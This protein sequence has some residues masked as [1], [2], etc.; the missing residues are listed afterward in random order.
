[1][2]QPKFDLSSVP[3]KIWVLLTVI[4]VVVSMMTGA[5]GTFLYRFTVDRPG[6]CDSVRVAQKVL[7]SVVTVSVTSTRGTSS[8]SGVIVRADGQILTNDHV[9]S[10]AGHN[11]TITIL[12]NSGLQLPATV[13]GTDPLT[14]LALLK[15]NKNKLPALPISWREPL[16]VGQP[17]V[18]LGAPLG[19]S[20]SVT[21]GIVSALDRNVPAPMSSGGTTVLTDAIQTD[22][23]INPG[24]S[25][26]P[27]VSCEGWFIGVNTAISTVPNS[28]G[29]PGG[30]NV[31]IGFA[32]PAATAERVVTDINLH[33]RVTHPWFGFAVAQV[34]QDI[35]DKYETPAGLFIQSVVPRGPAAQAGLR[36]GDVINK[37]DGHDAT[38][39]RLALTLLTAKIGEK[40]PLEI[41]RNGQRQL[42]TV[43]LAEQ[44][45]G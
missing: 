25:G 5:L 20:G 34:T 32:V 42:I 6:F 3:K 23:A 10:G 9:I 31:G 33:G 26:G 18:A 36:P 8:G 22:A 1:M 29:V 2:E 30:G 19:L 37:I 28:Q 7:P 11:P 13:M 4:V 12:F 24:N 39:D 41:V 45:R 40:V 43:T 27:L 16:S 44:P 15:V 38:S 21:A 14:D 17:V 35:A